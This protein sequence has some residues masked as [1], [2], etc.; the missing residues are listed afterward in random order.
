MVFS[1]IGKMSFIYLQRLIRKHYINTFLKAS[2]ARGV[3][4]ILQH[5]KR[6]PK[7]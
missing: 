2:W 6:N 7:T 3:C 5:A 1:N 4:L